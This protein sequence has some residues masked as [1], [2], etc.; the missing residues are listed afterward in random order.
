MAVA[1]GLRARP[2]MPAPK[3]G[4]KKAARKP[5][6]TRGKDELEPVGDII[7]EVAESQNWTAQLGAHLLLSRWPALVGVANAEHTEP[8]GFR[9]TVLTVRAES[10]TW[11]TAIRAIAPQLVAKLNE[12]LGQGTVTRV[13]VLGPAAPS[14]KH[15]IR[16]V[17]DG[18]GP[19]DT[20]G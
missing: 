16:S 10:S 20:Y 19:R 6:T 13:D 8:V 2:D 18:R 11:A 12:Q 5:K 14:W 3:T 7:A 9:D 1:A 4:P 15:G 17:S